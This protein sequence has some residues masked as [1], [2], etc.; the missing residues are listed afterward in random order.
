MNS[1]DVFRNALSGLLVEVF[2]GPP[3]SE[4][5]IL[6]PK[7]PGFLRQMEALSAEVASSRPM[8]GHTTIAAHVDH[9]LYGLSLL[10]RWAAGEENPWASADWNASW[11]RTV[12]TEAQWSDLC[13]RFRQAVGEWQSAVGARR[14]WNA[15]T[16][17]GAISSCAHAAYHLGAVRQILAAMEANIAPR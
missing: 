2:E 14:Q 15:L 3:G 5:F 13:A 10:N 16:A 4:A 11:K 9:V 1:D 6:N 8:P 17:S 7:D 12:V